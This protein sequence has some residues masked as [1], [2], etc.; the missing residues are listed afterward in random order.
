[1]VTLAR[2]MGAVLAL[3]ASGG[4]ASTPFVAQNAVLL[5]APVALGPLPRAADLYPLCPPAATD[6]RTDVQDVEGGVVLD[7]TANDD[8]AAET[9]R[10]RAAGLLAAVRDAE[11]SDLDA[12]NRGG[13]AHCPVVVEDTR[14]TTA[15][16]DRGVRFMVLTSPEEV[17]WLRHEARA[18][19][20]E[21]R[22]PTSASPSGLARCPSALPSA[23]TIARDT[24]DG[25]VVTI[26]SRDP[27]VSA[28]IQARA[29]HLSAD[30]RGVGPRDERLA[31]GPQCPIVIDGT[32][33]DAVDILNGSEITLRPRSHD[34]LE[35]LRRTVHARVTALP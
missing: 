17:D 6:A 30:A 8:A 11:H 29:W 10:A 22:V 4:C 24:D 35:S 7:V 19:F 3:V 20:A 33:V 23:V 2:R 9:I 1:M 5:H 18:R 16:I 27:D 34:G 31:S 13:L 25:V 21:L 15:P 14:V 32:S 26:T 28:A 12:A